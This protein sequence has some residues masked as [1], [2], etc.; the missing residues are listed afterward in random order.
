MATDPMPPTPLAPGLPTQE[1]KL[2]ALLAHL[3]GLLVLVSGFG[4]FIA[5]FVIYLMYSGKS[6]FVAFHALQ[7]LVWQFAILVVGLLIC[8]VGVAVTIPLGLI[9]AIIAGMRA[10][11]GELY[12]YWVVGPWARRKVGI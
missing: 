8:L 12:E 10:Y 2:W 5:P 7:S 3:S 6:K 1:E 4:Q 9:F 11:D